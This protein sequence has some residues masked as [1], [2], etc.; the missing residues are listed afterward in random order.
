MTIIV[1]NNYNKI[2]ICLNFFRDTFKKK[3]IRHRR[4]NITYT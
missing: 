1:N 2:S 4:N 3:V